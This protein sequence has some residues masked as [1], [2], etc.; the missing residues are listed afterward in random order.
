MRRNITIVRL[1]CL[2]LALFLSGAAATAQTITGSVRGTVTDPSGAVVAGAAV[3]VTNTGTG[4]T[5]NTVTDKSGLYSVGFLVLGNYTV[6]A[7]APGFET[8]S[9]GPFILQVDQIV[10]ADAK[11]EVG[12]ASATVNVVADQPLLLDIENSTISTSISSSALQNMPMD[13][14]NVQIATLFVP[15]SI[16]PNS[17]AMG[18]QQGT[19]RDAYTTHA[20]EPADAIPS[21][22]EVHVSTGNA[23]AEFGNVNGGEVV[24][25]TKGGTNNSTEVFLDFMRMAD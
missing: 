14:L 16:N 21:F 7:T 2:A 4:V 1:V 24:M 23:D 25:V 22:N 10:T 9:V 19:G 18:G 5:T 8:S 17:S 20:A 12:K 13:G 11:L 3:A 6:T 15:G